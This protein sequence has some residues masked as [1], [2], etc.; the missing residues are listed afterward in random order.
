M[1]RS[2]M[3]LATALLLLSTSAFAQNW[4]GLLDSTADDLQAQRYSRARHTTI[5]LIN[6]MMDNL[7]TGNAAA[8]TMGL[9]VAYRAVAEAGMGN[10]EEADW[11]RHVALAMSPQVAQVDMSRFGGAGEWFTSG[12]KPSAEN[13]PM[14]SSSESIAAGD[15]RDPVCK[16]KPY[17]KY[18]LGAVLGKVS[19]PVIVH[20]LI[21]SDGSVRHP[22]VVSQSVAPTLLYAATEAVK[23]WQFE[24]ATADGK[25]SP[26]EFDLTVNFQTRD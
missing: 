8:Y 6:S 22:A 17:P 9:T 13:A 25:P 16:Y 4:R 7:N 10:Y 26:V 3:L 14:A 15:R 18:P 24:P 23:R 1:T 11:Y 5:K 19:A 20:V 2:R 12:E 21:D